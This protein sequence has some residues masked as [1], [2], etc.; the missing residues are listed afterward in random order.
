MGV[1]PRGGRDAV[2]RLLK[3]DKVLAQVDDNARAAYE[4]RASRSDP[5]LDAGDEHKQLAP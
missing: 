2:A 5:R 3:A 4:L 1:L